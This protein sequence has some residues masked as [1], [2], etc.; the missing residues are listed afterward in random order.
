MTLETLAGMRKLDDATAGTIRLGDL[1]VRRL[2]FG[3][4]RISSARNAERQVDRGEAVKLCRRVV[5]R[6]VNFIDIA[7]VY[8]YGACEEILAE[9]LHPYPKDLVIGTKAGFATV[10]MEPGV[11]RLPEDGRPE[12]IRAQ[13]EISLRRLKL[14]VI[15]LYQA[16]VPDPNVPYAETV[17]AFADLQREG[18]VR[19]IGVSNVTPEQLKIAQSVCQVVSVQNRYNIGTRDSEAVLAACEAGGMAFLPY[20]PVIVKDTPADAEVNA[21]AQRHGALPQQ[22]A[23]AWLLGHS[24]AM[25]PI[26]GTSNRQHLDENVDAAWLELGADEIARLDAVAAQG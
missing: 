17:G 5:E 10:Q 4:M 26:P 14:D 15:D 12:H 23:L 11:R 18:K 21:I 16:H 3:A 24:R 20:R 13:C 8:G 2:G 1:T 7:D 19:H 25:L 6:G 22:V 9:A